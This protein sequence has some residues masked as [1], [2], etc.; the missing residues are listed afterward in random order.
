MI[1]FLLFFSLCVMRGGDKKRIIIT[2]PILPGLSWLRRER[3]RLES[4]HKR[5]VRTWPRLAGPVRNSHKTL[6]EQ[7]SDQHWIWLF[8]VL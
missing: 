1:S 8:A 7:S 4:I 2:D 5:E 6:F 3:A